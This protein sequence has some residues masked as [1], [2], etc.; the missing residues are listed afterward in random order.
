MRAMEKDRGHVITAR[1]PVEP[2]ALGKVMMHEHLHSDCVDW[3]KGEPIGEEHPPTEERR[4]Y[5][6]ENAIPHLENCRQY[7][8][9][10]YVD[11]TMPPWRAWPTLYRE[12]SERS[13]VHIILATGFYR[14]IELGCYWAKK[15]EWQLA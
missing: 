6:L 4:R 9:G 10:A 5:L 12:V 2:A 11:V 7:G 8:M 3:E 14:E 13:G 15:P 1:G